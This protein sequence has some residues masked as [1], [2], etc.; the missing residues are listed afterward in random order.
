MLDL[1][2]NVVK[3][4]QSQIARKIAEFK[5]KATSA[6]AKKMTPLSKDFSEVVLKHDNRELDISDFTDV[7]CLVI[8][9]RLWNFKDG[10]S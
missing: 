10:W 6:V 8:S 9:V 7:L 4:D 3:H 2:R 5:Q 1:V